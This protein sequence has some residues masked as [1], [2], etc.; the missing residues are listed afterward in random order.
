ML[1]VQKDFFSSVAKPCITY[2]VPGWIVE[3]TVG[4]LFDQGEGQNADL[5]ANEKTTDHDLRCG[6]HKPRFFGHDALFGTGQYA[7]D[8][9]GFGDLWE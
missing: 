2:L 7:S 4:R 5:D 6:A 8:S 3:H 1:T 9:V